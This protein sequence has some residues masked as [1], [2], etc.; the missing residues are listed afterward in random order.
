MDDIATI[1]ARLRVLR[2]WRGMTQAQLGGLAGMAPTLISMIENGQRPLDRRSQIAAVA[3]ALGVSETDLVGGPHLSADRLQSDPH[4]AIPPLREALQLN[5]ITA[6]A[7]DYARPLPELVTEMRETI[8]PLHR[9]TCD[10]IKVGALLPP[11]LDE[12]HVHVAAPQD[13]AAHKVALET[14]IDACV[15]ATSM[16][17][18]LGYADL[19]Q[20]AA[21]RAREAAAIL[22]DPVQQG[23]A[24]WAWLLSLPREGARERKLRLIEAAAATMEPHAR[25]SLGFQVLGMITLTASMAAAARQRHDVS[26]HWIGEAAALAKRVADEPMQ[27]WGQFSPTNVRIWEV[28]VGVERGEAGGAV[29]ERARRVNLSLLPPRSSRRAAF[30]ADTGRG[31]A[32]DPRT[33]PEAV[34]WLRQ[35]E[36]AAPQRIRN[37]A[38]VRETVAFLLQRANADAGRRE[39]RGLAARIGLPH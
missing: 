1:G 27:N 7:G 11:L 32:R 38:P 14:M 18:A 37:S 3:A 34:R 39:L 30:L 6:P 19:A 28:A 12:L 33:R 29:L 26:A 16:C 2:R 10:Y 5:T 35:A 31:L 21:T 20:Q 23:K 8:Y 13:E 17:W 24:D 25:D 36:A 22:G 9:D 15:R 4:S